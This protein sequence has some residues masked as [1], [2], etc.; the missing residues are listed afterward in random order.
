MTRHLLWE[1]D[2]ATHLYFIGL[3]T[4]AKSVGDENE[5]H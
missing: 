5:T 2:R 4:G 1:G 3:T